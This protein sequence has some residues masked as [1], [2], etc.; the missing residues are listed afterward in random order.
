[1]NRAFKGIGIF[2]FV[3]V[4]FALYA[5]VTVSWPGTVL[6]WLWA[7]NPHGHAGLLALGRFMGVPFFLLAVALIIIGVGWLRRRKWA[8]Y[9]A[10]IG[11]PL[12]M[13]ADIGRGVTGEWQAGVIGILAGGLAL[14][15][16]AHPGMRKQFESRN[17]QPRET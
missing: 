5:G 4:F 6:D 14:A 2:F 16:I 8:W 7:L 12:N 11:I 1:M 13:M 15:L 17:T 10:I 3:A 9:S